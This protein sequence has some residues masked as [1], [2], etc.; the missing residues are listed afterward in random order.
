M[1]RE[2]EVLDS[3]NEEP[4]EDEVK[5]EVFVENDESKRFTQIPRTTFK[6]ELMEKKMEIIKE[7]DHQKNLLHT[8]KVEEDMVLSFADD[9]TNKK[10]ENKED[11]DS[12][13]DED[14]KE[15]ED[16]EVE[17]DK[18]EYEDSDLVEDDRNEVIET[19]IVAQEKNEEIESELEEDKKE[20]DKNEEIE[21]EVEEDKSD[22][23]DKSEK[24]NKSDKS[25][26]SNKSD[27]SDKSN[28]SDKRD[29]SD[30][31]D[32]NEEIESEVE[33]DKK[34]SDKNEEIESEAENNESEIEDDEE[35][36]KKINLVSKD[37]IRVNEDK[38]I[39]V[40]KNT[41]INSI[42]HPVGFEEE[43]RHEIKI[44]E[45]KEKLK[46]DV[47]EEEIEEELKQRS[48]RDIIGEPRE[49]FNLQHII[50]DSS[51][52]EI[53]TDDQEI[54][55]DIVQNITNNFKKAK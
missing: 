24:S 5:K 45:I 23:S 21:S 9:E 39:N 49:S 15:H 18:K 33:E 38:M 27:K 11:E 19:H 13:L 36:V 35:K 55:N 20:S 54:D 7:M 47:I 4:S 16:S 28:K 31:N 26:K 6:S 52:G 8:H 50:K 32:K 41:K 51:V 42:A 2:C 12:E 53:H 43:L 25:D 37:G 48:E 46:Q 29:K 44:E 40:E 10:Q 1:N 17:E 34:E 3:M 14:K 30:K 22:K